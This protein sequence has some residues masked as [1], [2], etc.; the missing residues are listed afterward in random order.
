MIV[1]G[2][3]DSGLKDGSGMGSSRTALPVVESAVRSM[4]APSPYDDY[5]REHGNIPRRGV[6]GHFVHDFGRRIVGG[7]YPP[8][9]T[10]PNEPEIALRFG[11]R[12]T[13]IREAMKCLAGKGLIE[14]KTRVGTRVRARNDWHHLDSDVMVWHYETGPSREIMR[15]IKDLRRVLEPQATVRAA[16]RATPEYIAR[17]SAAF[18]EMSASLGDVRAH[19]DADLKFHA[20]IFA[21]TENM[22][23]AQLIDLIGVAIYA[24]RVLS[25]RERVLESQRRVLDLHRDILDA[26]RDHD[27]DGA[28]LA[29]HR[30]LDA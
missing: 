29:S 10:L 4:S 13:I 19:S 24:N 7:E 20:A 3:K 2:N 22:I 15:Y 28:L 27:Q 26:I 8:G 14:I 12:R 21:A 1:A 11:I 9:A 6:F 17:I 5:V 23:Y 30:L 18:D 16:E 25:A